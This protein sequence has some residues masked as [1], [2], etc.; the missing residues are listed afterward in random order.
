MNH[1]IKS[2]L[3]LLWTNAENRSKFATVMGS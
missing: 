3:I 2:V 1:S